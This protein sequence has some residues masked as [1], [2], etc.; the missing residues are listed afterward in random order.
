MEIPKIEEVLQCFS[1]IITQHLGKIMV[2]NV[3]NFRACCFPTFWEILRRRCATRKNCKNLEFLISPK[4]SYKRKK[5]KNREISGLDLTTR[6]V[7]LS[8]RKVWAKS[9]FRPLFVKYHLN[10]A[11]FSVVFIETCKF[12]NFANI[13]IRGPSQIPPFNFS[14]LREGNVE[15]IY[16]K[17]SPSLFNA[18]TNY[19][20]Y[21]VLCEG[22]ERLFS[23][24]VLKNHG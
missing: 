16:L 5:N 23:R 24:V 4:F 20:I 18:F 6:N 11:S 1:S 13:C 19:V 9:N 3:W 2:K 17:Q 22:E 8:S 12:L 10:H 7:G 21:Q 15:Q 14:I